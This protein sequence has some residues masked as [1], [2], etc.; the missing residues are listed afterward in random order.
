MRDASDEI[1]IIKVGSRASRLA[2]IQS[3]LVMER[4]ERAFPGIRTELVTMKTTGDRILDKTLDKIGGKGLFVRELDEALRTGA[5]DICVHSLKD[6]P[7]DIDEAIP[8]AALSERE[9]ARDVLIL[10]EGRIEPDPALP[11]GTSSLRRRLQIEKLYP[12]VETAPVRGNVETRLKKLDEGMYSGLVMAAAGIK[13]LGLEHRI[14]RYFGPDEMIPAPCQGIL[15]IQARQTDDAVME[16]LKS[17]S[18][19]ESE[20]CAAAERAFVSRI[21]ADCGSPDTAYS[22]IDGDIMD[23]VGMRYDEGSG[24]MIRASL[25]SSVRDRD[26]AAALGTELAER[27]MKSAENKGKVWLVGAGPGDCTLMTIKGMEVLSK[28]DVVIYDALIGD[29]ILSM[30][31]ERA[32]LIYAGKRSGV[33]TLKQDEINEA[34]LDKALQGLN[35]VRLK[36]GDPFLFGRGGEE[37]ELLIKN[38]IPYEIV[39]GVTSAFAVPAYAG[40]P[41]THRDY[42]SS[43]H[44]I[45]GHRRKPA[46]K[47]QCSGDTAPPLYDIDFASLVKSGGTLVFLMGVSSLRFI[48]KG[49]L[50]AGMDPDTPAAIVE[51]GTTSEQRTVSASLSELPDEA[52]RAKVRMPAVIVI[53]RVASLADSLSWRADLPLAGVRAVVTRPKEL[54]SG[55]AA[56]L[57]AKGAEVIELPVIGIEPIAD[58]AALDEAIVRLREGSYEWIVFTSPSGV[59]VFLEA[60]MKECDLRALAGCKIAVIGR[61]SERELIRYGIRP[62]MIP[63]VYDGETLGKELAKLLRS[64]DRILIPRAR[65]G[66]RALTAELEASDAADIEI[67]DIASYETVYKKPEWF[68]A[69]AVFA[70]DNTYAVFT[71]ASTVRGFVNACPDMDM[72]CVN[73]VCIGRQTAAEASKHGMRVYISAEATLES[74]VQRLEEAAG[75]GTEKL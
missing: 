14:S 66:N 42:C 39:P 24:Q 28:A 61:G 73:A 9:D 49:L 65:I 59:K 44:V 17:I 71:S 74:L 48:V 43:V 20:L 25:R 50:D 70:N 51:K 63:S 57:R 21:G 60:L 33:H 54:S 55:L 75:T 11:I 53:G 22:W 15:G 46:D 5:C 68:D 8:L 26:D 40:I 34:L 3:E 35:V 32:E 27:L 16:I 7:R 10:P 41:V 29:S 37:V 52:E 69:G 47:H 2:V 13:R 36:G 45:T 31:P 1:K 72:S 56:R 23:I 38:G 58:N 19:R 18:V 64:G 67:S 30:M 62:D 6:L 4:I 12:G